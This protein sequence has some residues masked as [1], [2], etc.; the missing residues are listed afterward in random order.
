MQEASTLLSA[1][2]T[3][4]S[5]CHL[6]WPAFVPVHDPLRDAYWGVAATGNATTHFDTDSIHISRNPAHL[7]KVS[8]TLHRQSVLIATAHG[9]KA[10]LY[11][12]TQDLG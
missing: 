5:N 12:H 11:M 8:H 9:T 4:L 2:A 1:L 10:C 3:A 7:Q 6:S